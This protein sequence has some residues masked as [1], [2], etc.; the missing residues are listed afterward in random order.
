MRTTILLIILTL[1]AG[2]AR[3]QNAIEWAV[4]LGGAS[5][6]RATCIRQTND[7]GYIVAGS[8]HSSDQFVTN[9]HGDY[10]YWIVKLDSN[11]TV[12]WEQSYGGT[13]DDE[14]QCIQQTT[15]GGYIVG[16]VSSSNDGDVQNNHGGTDCWILRLDSNGKIIWSKAYGGTNR[17]GTVT[18]E[19]T[20]DGGFVFAASTTST[21]GDVQ[22]RNGNSG[23]T[24]YWVVKLRADGSM[25]WNATYG[26]PGNDGVSRI[27]QTVDDGFIVTGSVQ[28]RGL[29]VSNL[30]G[31]DGYDDC[32]ILKLSSAG[33]IDWEKSLGGS[34]SDDATDIALTSDG[35]YIVAGYSN[36]NNGD[37]TA[38]TGSDVWIVKLTAN[39]MIS[40]NASPGNSSSYANSIQQTTDGGYVIGGYKSIGGGDTSGNHGGNDFW[41]AKLDGQGTTTWEKSYGGSDYDNAY[42]IQQTRDGGYIVSGLSSS[43]D[44]QVFG[45]HGGIDEWIVKLGQPNPKI[46]A[47]LGAS[48]ALT[49]DTS[50]LD[51]VLVTNTGAAPLTVNGALISGVDAADYAFVPAFTSLVIPP[52]STRKILVLFTPKSY[53]VHSATVELYSN[54]YPATVAKVFLSERNDSVKLFVSPLN[55]DLGTFCP[56]VSSDSSFTIRCTVNDHALINAA[57][58]TVSTSSL[59]LTANVDAQVNFHFAG[60]PTNVA[61]KDSIIVVDSICG[62]TSIVHITGTVATPVLSASSVT[63]LAGIGTTVQ[64]TL[65]IYN[66]GLAAAIIATA[67]NIAPFSFVNLS[68][69]IIVPAQDSVV[70]QVSYTIVDS[71][72]HTVNAQ[73][74]AEP[75]GAMAVAS[76]SGEYVNGPVIKVHG[77]TFTSL[78]CDTNTTDTITVTNVGTDTLIIRSAFISGLNALDFVFVA[79]L[80]TLVFAP[81]ETK[82]LV[83]RYTPHAVGISTASLTMYSNSKVDS[84]IVIALRKR[85][86]SVG[87][88][89]SDTI[90]NLGYLQINTSRDTPILLINNGAFDDTVFAAAKEVSVGQSQFS[91][92]PNGAVIVLIHFPGRA[93]PGFI[94]DTVIFTEGLCGVTR[95]V[96]IVGRIGVLPGGGNI[97]VKSAAAYAGEFVDIPIVITDTTNL[98]LSGTTKLTATLHFNATLLNPV[99]PTPRGTII[100]D[101]V[102]LIPLTLPAKPIIGDTLMFLHFQAMLGND[103]TTTLMLDSLVVVDG[104][105]TAEAEPGTFTLL[106]VCKKGYSPLINPNGFAVLSVPYP[107]PAST[108]TQVK[109]TTIETG[110]T[111]VRMMNALGM[112]IK[113]IFDDAPVVGEH[114]V[115]IATRDLPSGAYFL[116]LQTP[117]IRQ[118]LMMEVVK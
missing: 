118:S 20:R 91:L 10:D 67:P 114:Q 79:P 30:H 71:S 66:T 33:S 4:C 88:T 19:Q 99:A 93:K 11:G 50:K 17:E 81:G 51:T 87:I 43:T 115:N 55:I 24:D 72:R 21:D 74:L 85:N 84:V 82:K 56:N 1:A 12:Q 60:S 83:M 65:T 31:S 48:G 58:V 16:G 108:T 13:G 25:Q 44:G 53:G 117:T 5:D 107:N 64:S 106:G 14:A 8:S 47:T 103:S 9:N 77:G 105:L 63:V 69:P 29:D 32:W 49:C 45:N 109:F 75:C 110:R 22:A 100:G 54:S 111:T 112:T 42:S 96:R 26:G 61:I 76:L 39:G 101:T 57:G 62:Q 89:V 102:R 78:P 18:I 28:A 40:W 41:A 73:F 104:A 3:G 37:H 52:D 34:Q 46:K 15:D 7:G 23:N 35:G 97:K 27:H 98:V 6:D 80:P 86:G 92:G 59:P 36:S 2:M 90:I 94:D 95:I 38:N 113:T 116:V 68:L 70:L